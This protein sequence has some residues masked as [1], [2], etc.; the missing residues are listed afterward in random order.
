MKNESEM[1]SNVLQNLIDLMMG[2]TGSKIKPKMVSLEVIK[3][4]KGMEGLEEVLDEASEEE[5]VDEM[6]CDDEDADKK[7]SLKEYFAC[8]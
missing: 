6:D 8:K 7:R 2:S 3:P 1:K 5:P 4:M